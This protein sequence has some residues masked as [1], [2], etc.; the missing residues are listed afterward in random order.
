MNKVK[1]HKH[2]VALHCLHYLCLHSFVMLPEHGLLSVN[3]TISLSFSFLLTL[4]L[5]M[6]HRSLM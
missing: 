1:V 3:Q 4:M 2:I 5:C 6:L